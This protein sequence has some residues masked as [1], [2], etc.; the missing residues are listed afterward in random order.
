MF[1]P[2]FSLGRGT[3]AVGST[4][5]ALLFVS[6]LVAQSVL[7]TLPPPP[8]TCYG[9][10]DSFDEDRASVQETVYAE[11]TRRRDANQAFNLAVDPAERAQ[12]MMAAMQTNPQRAIELMQQ[13]RTIA[14]EQASFPELSQ[15]KDELEAEAEVVL[16]VFE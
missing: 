10:Q 11:W 16:G 8:T 9:N 3:W 13:T 2:A 1:R 14:E 12:R 6:P 4:L 5:G 15:R 7:N